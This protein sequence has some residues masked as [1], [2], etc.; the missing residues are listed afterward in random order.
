VETPRQEAEPDPKRGEAN[1]A[2]NP[3]EGAAEN[4]NPT[5]D[6][7]SKEIGDLTDEEIAELAQKGKSGLLKRLAELTAKRKLAE[8]R[9]AQLESALRHQ[10]STAPAEEV[11][12]NPFASIKDPTE[13]Q[14]KAKEVSEVIEWAEG[15]LDR[16]DD[17]RADDIVATVD[18]REYTKASIKE[19]KRKAQKSRDKYL[20]ARWREFQ[21]E[22]MRQQAEIAAFESA[23]KEI[24]WLD[25]KESEPR[26]EFDKMM[27]DPRL[28]KL[29][30]SVPDL[31]PVMPWLVAHAANSIYS[32]RSIPIEQT[33]P[34][35]NKQPTLQPSSS[36]ASSAA[37][38][39]RPESQ[40]G[41]VARDAEGRFTK[42]GN[43]DDFI[44]LRTAQL[45][46]RRKIA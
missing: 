34:K 5:K 36:P 39:G 30:Q 2:A 14:T 1:E 22:A 46:K 6:V 28:G 37:S 35:T 38:S 44:A 9:A 11:D 19:I 26:K 7:L 3:K 42:T 24:P 40:D 8:E 43:P 12:N 45:S 13:F 17:A 4:A 23:R 31:A 15:V 32:R 16:A 41:S 29:R 33:P 18:G 21:Q 27:A 10:A 20:P 25:D